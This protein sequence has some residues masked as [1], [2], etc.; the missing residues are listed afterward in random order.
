MVKLNMVG[1][2]ALAVLVS[3]LVVGT[4]FA[5]S[6]APSG[7]V[8]SNH[9][10]GVPPV[11]TADKT[12]KPSESPEATETPEPAETA[13]P[14]EASGSMLSDTDAAPFVA[15]LKAAGIV[16]SGADFEAL[17]AKVGVGGAVRVSAFAKASGKSAADI[18]T[19]FQAGKGWGE[20]AHTL[21]LNPG[22]GWIMSG[23]HARGRGNAT[24]ANKTKGSDDTGS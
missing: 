5:T 21:G 3:M 2:G 19:M 9:D 10:P 12:A 4:V 14:A 20:I 6:Q 1:R 16:V 8:G 24:S 18:V 7:P 11:Q 13:E 23:G 22:I 17:A 15:K